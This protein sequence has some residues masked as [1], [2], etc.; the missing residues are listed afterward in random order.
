M[1]RECQCHRMPLTTPPTLCPRCATYAQRAAG[2]AEATALARA[3]G[4]VVA[5]PTSGVASGT[6]EAAALS[7]GQSGG[8]EGDLLAR[9]RRLAK[10][11]GW[12]CYHTHRSERSEPGF[13]D[14]VLTN[15]KVILFV[16]L[17]TTKGKL[18]PQQSQWHHLLSHAH[19]H[20]VWIWRPEQWPL[21]EN[22]L[23]RGGA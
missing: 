11:H 2:V 17:K 16:E 5:L 15:G 9:V 21:I 19:Y 1:R 10:Q 6:G 18:T 3:A 4:H 8:S 12:L 20:E 23:A 14:L 7:V 13:P 22:T